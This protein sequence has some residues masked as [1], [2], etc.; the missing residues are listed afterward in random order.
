MDRCG[1]PHAL[2][3]ASMP[4]GDPSYPASP[5]HHPYQMLPI[6]SYKGDAADEAK[7][8][9]ERKEAKQLR[10]QAAK[11]GNIGINSGSDL[12]TVKAKYLK[13]RAARIEAAATAVH[14]ERSGEIRLTNSGTHAKVLLAL[15]DLGVTTPAGK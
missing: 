13:E 15:D 3:R 9:R 11:L 2:F 4:Q 6:S 1:A 5:R 10:K 7:L 12:L 14:K 8:E